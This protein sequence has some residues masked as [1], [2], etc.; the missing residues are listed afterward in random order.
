MTSI[1]ILILLSLSTCL[2]QS[3]LAQDTAVMQDQVNARTQEIQAPRAPQADVTRSVAA[4]LSNAVA[5][6]PASAP[7][8]SFVLAGVQIEGA[9]AVA[10]AELASVYEPLLTQEINQQGLKAL[11]AKLT[12]AYK[13]QG[14]ALSHAE[15]P[16][17]ML[18]NGI[19]RVRMVEGKV[20]AALVR[21][22][23]ENSASLS[24]SLL[25]DIGNKPLQQ[26]AFERALLRLEDL[27]GMSLK[28]VRL[29]AAATGAGQY[30]LVVDL[31]RKRVRNLVYADNRGTR[32]GGPVQAF[33][34]TAISSLLTVGDE[35]KVAVFAVPNKPKELLYF[36]VAYATPLGTSGLRTD[37]S[38][39]RSDATPTLQAGVGNFNGT[40]TTATAGLSYPLLRSRAR[41][42]WLRTELT[43]RDSNQSFNGASLVQDRIRVARL[44][45]SGIFAEGTSSRLEGRAEI[46]KGLNFLG[47]RAVAGNRSRAD[48]RSDFTKLSVDAVYSV[49]LS[50]QVSVKFGAAGQFAPHG[51]LASEEF[52]L[53]GARFGRAFNYNQSMGDS[54]IAASTE[55]RFTSENKLFGL[56]AYQLFG[57]GDIG[58][59]FNK[60]LASDSIASVGGGVRFFIGDTL[61]LS[62]EGGLPLLSE[63]DSP[64][65]WASVTS[66]F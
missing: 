5:P 20:S 59:S 41:S 54:G 60:G 63:L 15:I 32:S 52:S 26:S 24:A 35:V 30:N 53:G 14:F 2:V 66:S 36:N 23:G 12:S 7:E 9:T 28:D 4:A 50:D 11:T 18:A 29:Q 21:I 62:V 46:S 42:L 27:D 37:I 6:D 13:S 40:N 33:A 47:A 43:A 38:A 17:Q 48:G 44:S 19:L 22:A 65:I 64:R 45:I 16:P 51:L 55:V 61:E 39:S 1:K 10:S 58:T 34:Q 56:A 8:G 31:Q 3:A 49:G 57:F 25:A